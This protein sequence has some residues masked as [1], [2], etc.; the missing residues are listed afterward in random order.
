MFEIR[1][2]R[3]C[4]GI[5]LEEHKTNENIRQEAK[6]MNVL[7]LMRRRLQWFGHICKREKEDIRRVHEIKVVGKRNWGR[8][9]HRWHDTTRKDLQSCSLNEEDAQNRVRWRSLINL[10]LRQ[11]PATRTGQSGDR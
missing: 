11:P 2:L 10:G 7:E 1:M 6:V 4:L 8:P 3:Y 9:K 5:T